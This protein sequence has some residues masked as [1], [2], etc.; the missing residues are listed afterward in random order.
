MF[1]AIILPILRS[2]N[3]VY[4]L[5]YNAPTMLPAG[6]QDD[7][8]HITSSTSFWSPAGSII[9]ALYHKLQTQTNAPEDE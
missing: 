2:T 5:W 3:C 1:W 6:D 7:V 4:S 9:S 8:E